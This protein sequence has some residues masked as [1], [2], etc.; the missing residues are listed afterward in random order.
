VYSHKLNIQHVR[1]ASEL[2]MVWGWGRVVSD[3]KFRPD[4]LNLKESERGK[5]PASFVFLLRALRQPAQHLREDF[6]EAGSAEASSAS[7]ETATRSESLIGW[8][9]FSP[10]LL[11]T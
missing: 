7:K 9:R 4:R 1:R 11:L 8:A 10:F 6:L 5:S 2:N 3:Y